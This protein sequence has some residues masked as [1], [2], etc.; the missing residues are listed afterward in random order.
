MGVLLASCVLAAGP[1][2]IAVQGLYEG[3]Y[4][5]E[6][7]EARVTLTRFAHGIAAG[8]IPHSEARRVWD[9]VSVTTQTDGGTETRAKDVLTREELVETLAVMKAAADKAGI[10]VKEHKV[11]LAAELARAIRDGMARKGGQAPP[12]AGGR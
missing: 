7:A 6:K 4:R 12:P 2:E 3:T 5:G 9:M 11:D 8:T 1:E 10:A